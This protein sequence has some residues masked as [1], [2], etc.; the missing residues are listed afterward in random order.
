MIFSVIVLVLHYSELYKNFYILFHVIKEPIQKE[1]EY[2]G[3]PY[4]HLEEIF[5]HYIQYSHHDVILFKTVYPYTVTICP[6]LYNKR[7]ARKKVK[8]DLSI[9]CYKLWIVGLEI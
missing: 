1:R 9:Y 2:S 8:C 7:N 6:V 4:A 5:F 3:A